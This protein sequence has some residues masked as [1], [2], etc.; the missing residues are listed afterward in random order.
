MNKN[1]FLVKVVAVGKNV[2]QFTTIV[3]R[4]VFPDK[5]TFVFVHKMKFEFM[6]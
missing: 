6:F 3:S 5:C 1:D 2:S 4:I